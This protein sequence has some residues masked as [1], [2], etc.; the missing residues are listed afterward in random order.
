MRLGMSDI[1]PSRQDTI[2]C[3]EEVS[4]M[5]DVSDFNR[6]MWRHDLSVSLPGE[7]TPRDGGWGGSLDGEKIAINGIGAIRDRC[8]R[9]AART[10]RLRNTG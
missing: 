8:G 1:Y 7:G 3:A 9:S 5:R 4:C 2:Q 6:S 10:Y